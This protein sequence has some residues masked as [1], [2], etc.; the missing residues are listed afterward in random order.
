MREWNKLKARNP[1]AKLVCLDIVPNTTAQAVNRDD[2]LNIGG[3]SDQ[4]FEIIDQ[5][6]NGTASGDS[7]VQAIESVKLKSD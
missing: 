6:A 3:F 1:Q 7:L 4:V 5:F 2:I